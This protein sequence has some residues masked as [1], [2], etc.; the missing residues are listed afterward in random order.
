MISRQTI[1]EI[2]LVAKIE[3][4]VQDFVALKKRGQNWRVS[5]LS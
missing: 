2:L 1:D 4:V 3:D 5:V